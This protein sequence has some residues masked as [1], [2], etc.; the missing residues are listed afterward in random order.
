MSVSIFVE[1]LMLTLCESVKGSYN[2][3]SMLFLFFP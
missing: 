3:Q 1:L 2:Q